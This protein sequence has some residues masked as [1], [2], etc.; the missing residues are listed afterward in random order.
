MN[1][2]PFIIAAYAITA[3]GTLALSWAS[4]QQMRAAEARA[5]DMKRDN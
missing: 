4:W 3:L 5:N 1:H 2:W